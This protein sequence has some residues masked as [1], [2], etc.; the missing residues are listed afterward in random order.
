MTE[1]YAKDLYRKITK[2]EA[3]LI[4]G[5][6]TNYILPTSRARWMKLLGNSVSV[7]VIQQLGAAI[8]ETGVFE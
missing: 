1:I 8:M 3:C 5:F 4:Q 6:P 7:P 2:E